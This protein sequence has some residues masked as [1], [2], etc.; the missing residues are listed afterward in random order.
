MHCMGEKALWAW[1]SGEL[2]GRRAKRVEAHLRQCPQCAETA[3]AYQEILETA[4]A[5]RRV[6]PDAAEV[7]AQRNRL[8]VHL[9][10]Q[11]IPRPVGRPAIIPHWA[12]V[13]GVFLLGLSSGLFLN[14][15]AG[16]W[17]DGST[18]GFEP[19]WAETAR[20]TNLEVSA[21]EGRPGEVELRYDTQESKSITGRLNAQA[22]QC[23]LASSLLTEP[24]ASIR[25][26][27]I[28]LLRLNEDSGPVLDALMTLARQDDNPGV[29]LKAVRLLSSK[30][31]D[32]KV[33][34]TL[35]AVFIN[36]QVEGIRI[37]AARNLGQFDPSLIRDWLDHKGV[38]TLARIP[39]TH[40]HSGGA[41]C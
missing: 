24:R 5:S 37:Q 22:V 41:P 31:H 29:R 33:R 32:A 12:I 9:S 28:D 19:N 10:A 20:F 26:R 39:L 8:M 17:N 38:P 25:L 40:S 7:L 15:H 16:F 35:L 13:T 6:L 14:R 3:A 11:T 23:A 18:E 4:T 1:A 27:H 36:D 30:L 21:A 2:D 34:E